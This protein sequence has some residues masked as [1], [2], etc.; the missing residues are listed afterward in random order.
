MIK[1][2]CII[3]EG[4][5]QKSCASERKTVVS[6]PNFKNS[7]TCHKNEKLRSFI[8]TVFTIWFCLISNRMSW[9]MA[10]GHLAMTWSF[11]KSRWLIVKTYHHELAKEN[12]PNSLVNYWG[13]PDVESHSFDTP[14]IIIKRPYTRIS[15]FKRSTLM[16]DFFGLFLCACA[17]LW[18]CGLARVLRQSSLWMR[19]Q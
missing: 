13:C 6:W 9:L 3:G 18:N 8:R 7:T 17:F 19:T 2:L 10:L 5:E 15:R 4:K 12:K 16:R 1:K 14:M 11:I